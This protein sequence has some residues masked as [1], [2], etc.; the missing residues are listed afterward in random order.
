MCN[1]WN[2]WAHCLTSDVIGSRPSKGG[3]RPTSYA[4][5]DIQVVVGTQVHVI[6]AKGLNMAIMVI[7]FQFILPVAQ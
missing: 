2:V 3:S 1:T 4:P 5:E 6:A 7:R